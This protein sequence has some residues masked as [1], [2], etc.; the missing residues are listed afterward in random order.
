MLCLDIVC[1]L[2][3]LMFQR[4]SNLHQQTQLVRMGIT[5]V[6]LILKIPAQRQH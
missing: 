2:N 3:M 1:V 5:L 4:I 6:P